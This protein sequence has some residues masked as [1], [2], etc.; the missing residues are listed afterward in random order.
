MPHHELI[1]AVTKQ[2]EQLKDALSTIKKL[3][4][5]TTKTQIPGWL[6]Q[7]KKVN[8][9]PFGFLVLD[10]YGVDELKD[11]AQQMLQQK[12]GFYFLLSCQ[13]N[14]CSFYSL[15]SEQFDSKVNLKELST[16]LKNSFGLRGG[17]KKGQLQGGGPIVDAKSLEDKLTML[18]KK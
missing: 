12:P 8:G 2:R 5:E 3:K 18:L 1:G 15:L 9:V 11:I 10:G 17:G 6:K 13:E 4:K 7:T 14:N 16:L